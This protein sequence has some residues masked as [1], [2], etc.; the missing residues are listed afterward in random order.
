MQRFAP[1]I[2]FYVEMFLRGETDNAFHGLLEFDRNI[3]PELIAAFHR[4]CAVSVRRF[5]VGVIWE[6]RDPSVIPFL[7][8]VLFDS[9]LPV[10]REAL[11]GLVAL[12]SPAALEALRMARTRKF[13]LRR[14]SEEF[15]DWLEEAIEQAEAKVLG[16]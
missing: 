10:W 5:L 1:H 7:G 2:D 4:E 8:G 14:E 16:A 9:E 3:L 15:H 13:P 11:N 12:A 6:Y